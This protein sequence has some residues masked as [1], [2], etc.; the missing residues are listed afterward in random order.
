[1]NAPSSHCSYVQTGI[2][3]TGPKPGIQID[4]TIMLKCQGN[5]C[6]LTSSE[7]SFYHSKFSKKLAISFRII[8]SVYQHGFA[9]KPLLK[10][11]KSKNINFCPCKVMRKK[12]EKGEISYWQHLWAHKLAFVNFSLLNILQL[13]FSFPNS[14]RSFSQ[15]GLLAASHCFF[16]SESCPSSFTHMDPS[17][18][19]RLS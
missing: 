1:M 3:H 12:K 16:L 6:N 9:I 5:F 18:A 8:H 11:F 15:Q 2:I 19:L 10:K 17:M 4:L 7:A 13:Y 14:L